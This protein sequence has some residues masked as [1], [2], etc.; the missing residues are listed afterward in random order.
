MDQVHLEV[1]VPA[2]PLHVMLPALSLALKLLNQ[3]SWIPL[4]SAWLHNVLQGASR[5]R[6]LQHNNIRGVAA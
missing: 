5:P 2:V 4:T 6:I 3:T 1:N